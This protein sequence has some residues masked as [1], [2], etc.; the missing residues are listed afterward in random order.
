[1]DWKY[2]SLIYFLGTWL[3]VDLSAAGRLALKEGEIKICHILLPR[4][5]IAFRVNK[6][7]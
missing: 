1:M 4:R 6:K 3:I 7:L 5:S 2:W